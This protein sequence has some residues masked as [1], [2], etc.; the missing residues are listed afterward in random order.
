MNL[1]LVVSVPFKTVE[2][3]FALGIVHYVAGNKNYFLI[4]KEARF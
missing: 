4:I 2:D 1:I 3:P